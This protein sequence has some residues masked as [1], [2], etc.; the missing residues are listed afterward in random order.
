GAIRSVFQPCAVALVLLSWLPGIRA[1]TAPAPANSNQVHP[2][3]SIPVFPLG[4]LTPGDLPA[5]YY[6]AMVELHFIDAD[7]LAFAFNTPG[8][9]KRDDNC[10]GSDVQRM[11]HAVVFQLPS[12]RVIKQ[13]DWEL[14]DFMDF[15]WGMADGKLL[16]RRCNRLESIGP[17][18]DPQV[19]IQGI[20]TVEDVSFSP[21]HSMVVVQEKVKADAEDKLS[22]ALPSVLAQ[23]TETQHTNVSFI[24]LNPVHMIGRAEI[25]SPSVIPIIS[26]GLFEVLTAPNDQWVVNLQVFRG[27]ERE[28]A[29][30]H[31][32]CPPVIQ[33]LSNT[34]FMATTCPKGDRRSFQGY[35]L[36]GS[37]LWQ[38]SLAPDQYDPQ[39][40]LIPSGVHFAIESLRLTHPHAA[41]DPLTKEDVL[42]EDIDIYDTLSGARSATFE[43]SPAYTGGRNVDFSP[44]GTRMAVL[45]HGAIEVYSL[46]DLAKALPGT[47]R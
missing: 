38:I 15:L 1:Q 12:G 9:L 34:M 27:A 4:Y 25:S 39:L 36:Q 18:L 3:M 2:Q 31:S 26:N 7:H 17:D 23:E 28:I 45:H 19:L 11:V 10:P 16:L 22:G 8:L 13:A 46:S 6:Y 32:L 41:L 29:T 43:T 47:S 35:N 14:Y 42:G 37:L 24:E 20:G 44:D 40:I 30:I 33:A 5:L 21:D